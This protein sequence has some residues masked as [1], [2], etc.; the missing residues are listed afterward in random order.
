[1]R[2]G[3]EP[4][5][6]IRMPAHSC[7]LSICMTAQPALAMPLCMGVLAR[8]IAKD[9]AEEEG[10]VAEGELPLQELHDCGGVHVVARVGHQ[11]GSCPRAGTSPKDGGDDVARVPIG[12]PEGRCGIALPGE[13]VPPF[14]AVVKGVATDAGVN[15]RVATSEPSQQHVEL[16]LF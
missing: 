16:A 2:W 7:K 11:A 14:K 5:K 9:L 8:P 3:K 15:L 6:Q 10:L 13:V 4:L 1:M 12:V